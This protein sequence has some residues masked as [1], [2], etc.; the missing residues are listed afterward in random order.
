MG[1]GADAEAGGGGDKEEEPQGNCCS[2]CFIGFLDCSAVVVRNVVACT[3][4]CWRF[5]QEKCVYP[6]KEKIFDFTDLI[7][8]YMRPF[9]KSYKVPYS[10]VPDFRF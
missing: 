5:T 6:V 10:R 3:S 9:K 7:V 2:R 4:T 8:G 1:E